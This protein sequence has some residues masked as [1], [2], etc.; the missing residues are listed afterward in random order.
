MPRR[1]RSGFSSGCGRGRFWGWLSEDTDAV[2][3]SVSEPRALAPASS[4]A[5]QKRLRSAQRHALDTRGRTPLKP[6]FHQRILPRSHFFH[7]Q[8]RWFW[9]VSAMPRRSCSSGTSITLAGLTVRSVFSQCW[10]S[11]RV[12]LPSR[13]PPHAWLAAQRD[14]PRFDP[15]GCERLPFNGRSTERRS[16]PSRRY[17]GLRGMAC[18]IVFMLNHP[19]SL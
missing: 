3:V 17:H 9:A 11:P 12:W 5:T 16:I 8:L 19:A 6:R 14:C 1:I 4:T 7:G 2:A 15:P 18:G 13:P 10:S